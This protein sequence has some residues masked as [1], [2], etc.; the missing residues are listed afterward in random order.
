MK[1]KKLVLKK[2]IVVNLGVEEMNKLR[3]GY[4]GGGYEGGSHEACSYGCISKDPNNCP[5]PSPLPTEYTGHTAPPRC[6]E[7]GCCE[8][9]GC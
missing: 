1:L 9:I 2:E 6:C 8:T 3:G 7:Y 4:E 5:K